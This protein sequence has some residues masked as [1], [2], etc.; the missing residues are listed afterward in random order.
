LKSEKYKT[1]DIV[2]ELRAQL[3]DSRNRVLE[4]ETKYSQLQQ[5]NDQLELNLGSVSQAYKELQDIY[6]Q[7]DASI[8]KQVASFED[9]IAVIS[10]EKEKLEQTKKELESQLAEEKELRKVQFQ[11]FTGNANTQADEDGR[12]PSALLKMIQAYQKLNRHPEDIFQDYF[13]LSQRYNA[14]IEKNTAASD[15]VDR[16]ARRLNENENLFARL[17]RELQETRINSADLNAKIKEVQAERKQSEQKSEQLDNQVKDLQLENKKLADSLNDTTYQLQHLLSE[18]QKRGEPIPLSLRETSTLLKDIEIKPN[19]PHQ[20]LVFS[21]VAELQDRN[22]DL[23][24]QVRQLT[25]KVKES[26]NRISEFQ[27]SRSSDIEVYKNALEEC[28]KTVTELSDKASYLQKKLDNTNIECENYKKLIHQLGD[29]DVTVK[30]E[31]IQENQARQRKEMDITLNAYRTETASEINL[32]KQELESSRQS[33]RDVKKN[34]NEMST[35]KRHLEHRVETL[36]ANAREM[37][38]ELKSAH[39]EGIVLNDRIDAYQRELTQTKNELDENKTR[40]E[41]LDRENSML[42]FR[43]DAA[44]SA[45]NDLKESIH[46]Q[47]DDKSEMTNLLQAIN[48]R[49]DN[50][51]NAGK[52]NLQK[53]AET[54]ATL[55]R[56]LQH[57]RD[58]LA[59]AEKQIDCYKAIDTSGIQDKYKEATIEIRLLKTKITETEKQLSEVNQERIIAQNKLMAAEE[60][61]K[62]ATT[63]VTTDTTDS[64]A[65]CNEHLRLLAAAED[66]VRALEA[67]IESY[68]TAMSES[69]KKSDALTEEHDQFVK[70]TQV[71]IDT[72]LKRVEE[73]TTAVSTVQNEAEMAIAEYKALN[74]KVTATQQELVEEKKA[75]EE[76]VKQLDAEHTAKK[77]EI[78]NLQQT[79]QDKTVALT[80]VQGKLES[81]SKVA[82]EQRQT[83]N[84]LRADVS[85]L[86]FEISQYKAT[87]AASTNREA[88]LKSELERKINEESESEE[89]WKQKFNDLEKQREKLSDAVAELVAKHAEWSAAQDKENGTERAE[90]N[91]AA[92]DVIEQLREVNTILRLEKDASEN[93]YQQERFKL[94]RA[95]SEMDSVKSQLVTLQAE[96]N[97]L[98][99]ENKELKRKEFEAS[100]SEKLACEAFR[101]QNQTLANENKALRESKQEALA[102]RAKMEAEIAP[103]Q[104]MYLYQHEFIL[105][106]LLFNT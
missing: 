84:T 35:L 99:E 25:D 54:I 68:T 79:L 80:D 38:K 77:E 62:K 87:I 60:E 90:F 8:N 73:S 12:P 106:T 46:K 10:R 64:N 89:S 88:S 98:A 29:G 18:V 48:A 75:L 3:E 22:K 72:L 82:E 59:N 9:K 71:T 58:A 70:Q 44:A 14:A 1:S 55:T 4:A 57:K 83:I 65:S 66:R 32:L 86:T 78:E 50:L 27:I 24:N 34:L 19:L 95:E 93:N 94:R 47:S 39:A 16:M 101:S 76:K 7:H 41:I 81:E 31:Q 100:N 91:R 5:Q 92:G 2:D 53:S 61:I 102:E 56:E 26:T 51:N 17:H 97:R 13:D 63:T 21:N 52:E 45:Y 49:M 36:T 85:N 40:T 96:F 33:E 104:R 15:S 74:E 28:R 11:N 105:L 43:V 42:K 20:Q 23:T 30:F 67:D 103:L 6:N 37:E 69:N